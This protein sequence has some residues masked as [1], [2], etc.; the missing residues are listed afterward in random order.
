MEVITYRGAGS[1]QDERTGVG[2]L[3]SFIN[4]AGHKTSG[5]APESMSLLPRIKTSLSFVASMI[6]TQLGPLTMTFESAHC[7]YSIIL[8]E[9]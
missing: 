9:K 7:M 3:L 2:C 1:S 6:Q 4:E 5:F 8:L